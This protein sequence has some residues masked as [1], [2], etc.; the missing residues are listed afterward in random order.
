MSVHTKAVM[1]TIKAMILFV[2]DQL[3]SLVFL[4]IIERIIIV[5]K[6]HSTISSPKAIANTIMPDLF[7]KIYGSLISAKITRMM[8]SAIRPRCGSLIMGGCL[9]MCSILIGLVYWYPYP[10]FKPYAPLVRFIASK[11]YLIAIDNK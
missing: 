1:T 6:V 10:C 2:L 7:C 4:D 11:H 5:N 9:M 8:L 3:F